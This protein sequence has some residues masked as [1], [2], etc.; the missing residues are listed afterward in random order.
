MDVKRSESVSSET[1]PIECGDLHRRMAEVLALREEV[2][3]YLKLRRKV[4]GRAKEGKR[5][6]D[7]ERE[8][9]TVL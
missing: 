5:L 2:A 6:S 4:E 1:L 9:I 8:S 7:V 3:S